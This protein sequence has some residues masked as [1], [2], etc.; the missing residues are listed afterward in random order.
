MEEYKK[1]VIQIFDDAD[2]EWLDSQ[3]G[4][5]PFNE[6]NSGVVLYGAIQKLRNWKL[7][8]PDLEARI[9]ART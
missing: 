5:F 6:T 7:S 1:Y 4:Q 8:V 3:D 2:A 9:V